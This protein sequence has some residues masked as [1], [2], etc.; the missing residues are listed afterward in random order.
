V[1]EHTF[2][3]RIWTEAREIEGAAPEHRG[4]IKHAPSGE[5]R[6]L[7]DMD[8]IQAFIAP[9]L[10]DMGVKLGKVWQLKQ[11]L[12]HQKKHLVPK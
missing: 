12:K 2:I 4:V 11:W 9:Y 10:E 5:K 3:I 6:Y 1:T 7:E 8:M